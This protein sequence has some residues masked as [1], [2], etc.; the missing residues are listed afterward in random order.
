[1]SHSTGDHT[2]RNEIINGSGTNQV[3]SE[4]LESYKSDSYV[5]YTILN[6]IKLD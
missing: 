4:F 5:R 6:I 1:M 3:Y 2:F